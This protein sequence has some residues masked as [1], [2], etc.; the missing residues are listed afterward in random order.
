MWVK[1]CGITTVADALAACEAGAD[2]IGLNFWPSSRR[3]CAPER[4]AEIVAALPPAVVAYGVFVDAGRDVVAATAE[5]CRLGGLQFHG[6]EEAQ[7]LVGWSL[8][9]IRAVRATSREVVAAALGAAQGYRILIDSPAGGGSGRRFDPDVVRG[10]DLS[11]AIVA[12]GLTPENVA[13]VVRDLAPY[14]VD[15]A[16]GVERSPGVKDHRLVREFVRRAKGAR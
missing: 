9:V 8:P 10:L 6:K 4:A 7:D 16:G 15:V 12:G 5:R 2:A 1:I 11:Q 3:Y 14:G 13:E